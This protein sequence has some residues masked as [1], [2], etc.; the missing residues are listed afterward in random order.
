MIQIATGDLA[1]VPASREELQG[2]VSALYERLRDAEDERDALRK[3]ADAMPFAPPE[4]G[5]IRGTELDAIGKWMRRKPE[6]PA[7]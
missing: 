5:M 4:S 2:L 6:L 3:W 7:R 1:A